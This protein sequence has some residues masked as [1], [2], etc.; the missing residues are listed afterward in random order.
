MICQES[1]FAFEGSI[2]HEVLDRYLSRALTGAG[3]LVRSADWTAIEMRFADL[4]DDPE[5][6]RPLFETRSTRAC[7][8][9]SRWGDGAEPVPL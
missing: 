3:L 1:Q 9:T 7:A 6:Q 8:A 5:R 2:S 4:H